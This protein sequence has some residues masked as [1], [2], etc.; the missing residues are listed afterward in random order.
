MVSTSSKKTG[1]VMLVTAVKICKVLIP[2]LSAV[3]D[4]ARMM[5]EPRDPASVISAAITGKR[6]SIPRPARRMLCPI[7]RPSTTVIQGNT[8]LLN[9]VNAIQ[10][11]LKT[12]TAMKPATIAFR[13]DC[14]RTN[15]PPSID[16]TSL[17]V[18]LPCLLRSRSGFAGSLIGRIIT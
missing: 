18:P 7:R 14:V 11:R 2:R 3:T 6:Q 13:T 12:I 10:K 17:R 5:L 15:R 1:H 8:R 4:A 16:V 9:S